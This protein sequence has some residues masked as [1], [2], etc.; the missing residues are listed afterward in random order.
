[1][2]FQLDS[3]LL[4]SILIFGFNLE[5]QSAL[6][7]LRQSIYFTHL[8]L[9]VQWTTLPDLPRW[10]RTVCLLL[11]RIPFWQQRS[12]F[13][14]LETVKHCRSDL[15]SDDMPWL[16]KRS[17]LRPCMQF[18]KGTCHSRR[19]KLDAAIDHPVRLRCRIRF[20]S[21]HASLVFE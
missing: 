10:S 8:A 7:W 12:C 5:N 16:L 17:R 11:P 4:P 20:S 6:K 2:K 14:R 18:G 15:C 1:M 9:A 13:T 19:T 21:V 3:T